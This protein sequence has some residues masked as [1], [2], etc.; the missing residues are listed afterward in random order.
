MQKMG[1]QSCNADPDLWMMA[2]YRPENKLEYYSYILYYVDDI[3]RIHHDPDNV[4]N[5]EV[6][7]YVPLKHGSV[8]SPDMYLGT[9]FK[10][11]QMESGLDL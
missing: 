4:L 10:S 11:M 7:R 9:K 2:E 6:N 5:K 1:Y 3:L 8:G